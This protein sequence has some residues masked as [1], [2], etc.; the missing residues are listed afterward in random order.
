MIFV[1]A[2]GLTFVLRGR[3][4]V[5][6]LVPIA[7]RRCPVPVERP[8]LGLR[9][10]GPEQAKRLGLRAGDR[11]SALAPRSRMAPGRLLT[12]GVLLDANAATVEELQA[13]PDIGPALAARIVA[14]RRVQPFRARRD[15]LR[16]PGIGAERLRGL[17][18]FLVELPD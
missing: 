2:S 1:A 11:W 16:V 7:P 12:V 9:C 13:L 4:P 14:A 10:L 6:K 8:D 15:V 17:L 18:P 5:P 3:E